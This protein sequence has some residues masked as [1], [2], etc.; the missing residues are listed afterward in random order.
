MRVSVN[1]SKTVWCSTGNQTTSGE[2]RQGQT[3]H[4]GKPDMTDN[5]QLET[6]WKGKETQS[7]QEFKPKEREIVEGS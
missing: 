7:I 1:V 6:I 2:D 3:P 5:Q 4:R